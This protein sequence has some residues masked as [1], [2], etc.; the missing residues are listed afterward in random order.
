MRGGGVHC[1]WVGGKLLFTTCEMNWRVLFILTTCAICY[2]C[3]RNSHCMTNCD[4][5]VC[6]INLVCL[7]GMD[8]NANEKDNVCIRRAKAEN[9]SIP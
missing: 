1:W 9:D 6:E 7:N 5:F 4:I 2:S 8:H 3:D